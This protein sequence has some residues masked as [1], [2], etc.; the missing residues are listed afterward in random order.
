M[1]ELVRS[2][3]KDG[4]LQISLNRPHKKNALT[5]DMYAALVAALERVA[6]DRSIKV[7]HLSQFQNSREQ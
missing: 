3:L 5:R 4:I 1:T 7:V 2:E 6:K